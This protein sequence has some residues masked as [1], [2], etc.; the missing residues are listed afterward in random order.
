M[1]SIPDTH[2]DL[3]TDEAN[4]LAYLATL[5]PD[6]TPQ[7]TPLW[8]NSDGTHI[9]INSAVGRTKDK[10]MRA[11]PAV[12]IVIQDRKVDNRYIQ[13]RGPVV[14]ITEKDALEHIDQLSM[15]YDKVHWKPVKGQT[16]V[17]YKILPA[18]VSVAE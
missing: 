15:K 18:S 4:A 3:L 12:A 7:V 17:I 8:F 16:R 11:R 9:L 10:N 6:G 2:K 1:D 14:E 13:V 5:M